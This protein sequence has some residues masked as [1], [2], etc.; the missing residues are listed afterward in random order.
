MEIKGDDHWEVKRRHGLDQGWRLLFLTCS[1]GVVL[2][3]IGFPEMFSSTVLRV[4][5]GGELIHHQG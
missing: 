3:V 2:E 5:Q 1:C 4:S